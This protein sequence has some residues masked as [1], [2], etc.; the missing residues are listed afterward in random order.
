MSP[1][2]RELPF[3]ARDRWKIGNKEYVVLVDDSLPTSRDLIFRRVS[4]CRAPEL[5]LNTDF[6]GTLLDLFAC[7]VILFIMLVGTPP[8]E[9]VQ[10]T[11]EGVYLQ[12]LEQGVT[13]LARQ[14]CPDRSCVVCRDPNGTQSCR[15]S[16]DAD[17]V[18]TGLLMPPARRLTMQSLR[19]CPWMSDH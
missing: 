14:M 13:G 6:F 8:F 9:R 2:G 7:G 11:D 5:Y 18:I 19:R 1:D 10:L 15:V 16:P 12:I 3:P 17:E 4:C